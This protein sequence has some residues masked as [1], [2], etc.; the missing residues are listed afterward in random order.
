MQTSASRAIPIA[1]PVFC[2]APLR[3]FVVEAWLQYG[4]AEPVLQ[5]CGNSSQ[6]LRFQA[7]FR[8]LSEPEMPKVSRTSETVLW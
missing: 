6:L 8:T 2:N 1:G 4:L 3:A 7:L 5:P